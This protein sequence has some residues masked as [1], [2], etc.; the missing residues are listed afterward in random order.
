MK[1]GMVIDLLKC[2]GCNSCTVACRG[3]N[4]TPPGVSFH[5]IKKYEVGKYPEAKMKFL[6]MPCMHCQNAPCLKVCPT[7]ATYR[8]TDGRILIDYDKCIGCR[9]CMI[10]C[11]FDSRHFIW[12]LSNYYENCG[13]TPF[14]TVK[15]A[16]F[17]EGTV[18]K[19]TFCGERLKRG[20]QPAC[21]ETCIGLARTFGDLDDPNSE[22]SRLIVEH[23]GKQFR[24]EL[25]T[26]PC[27]FYIKG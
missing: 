22:V 19:C 27:V 4:G 20:E 13:P 5:K 1:L 14:E 25:G 2:V 18:A 15:F 7:G 3:E 10:A 6:P 17:T 16:S 12:E 24:K 11:P 26:D 21:V 8:E 23:G 9:A